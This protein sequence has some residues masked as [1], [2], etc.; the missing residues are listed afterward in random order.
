MLEAMFVTGMVT[1]MLVSVVAGMDA[2]TGTAALRFGASVEPTSLESVSVESVSVGP[3]SVEPTKEVTKFEVDGEDAA[4]SLA[5]IVLSAPSLALS[6]EVSLGVLAGVLL[7]TATD[8]SGA[9]AACGAGALATDGRGSTGSWIGVASAQAAGVGVGSEFTVKS[10]EDWDAARGF[11]VVGFTVIGFA[12]I[13]LA[14]IGIAAGRF[15]IVGSTG[16]SA[17]GRLSLTENCRIEITGVGITGGAEGAGKGGLK[18]ELQGNDGLRLA[19]DEGMAVAESGN[20]ESGN[21]G[22]AD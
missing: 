14:M 16:S 1:G 7:S 3:T 10:P 6:L 20:G 11:A 5:S 21:N 13:G 22:R 15:A 2:G 8:A 9:L 17:C 18:S 12:I 4:V 19:P